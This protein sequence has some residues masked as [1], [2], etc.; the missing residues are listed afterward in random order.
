MNKVDGEI[1]MAR[2][3]ERVNQAW[4]DDVVIVERVGLASWEGVVEVG[5]DI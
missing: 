1:E 3:G 5:E 2:A 4:E